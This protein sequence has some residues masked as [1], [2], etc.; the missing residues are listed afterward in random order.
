MSKSI[1]ILKENM[2]AFGECLIVKEVIIFG[3][4]EQMACYVADDENRREAYTALREGAESLTE[5]NEKL[6][7]DIELRDEGI[8][9]LSKTIQEMVLNMKE[10][11]GAGET[12][13]ES[14]NTAQDIINLKQIKIDIDYKE[15]TIEIDLL[16]EKNSNLNTEKDAVILDL[17]S[18][19]EK[20][21]EL[22][23]TLQLQIGNVTAELNEF[24]IQKQLTL[25]Q[26]K[27]RK[28]YCF[29]WPF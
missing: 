21:R 24:L 29:I 1:V 15:Y 10:I 14:L 9:K 20:S 27:K 28:W 11:T 5:E 22:E 12:I 23:I 18:A 19:L 4:S 6:V 17:E 3:L 25:L 2:L 26:A 13:Q 7:E 8:E 16:N